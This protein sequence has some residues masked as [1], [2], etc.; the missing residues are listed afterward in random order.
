MSE[1]RWKRT[2]RRIAEL[3]GGRRMPISG[4]QRGDT[5]DVLHD[6][7]SIEVK[8]RRRLPGWLEEAMKQAEAAAKNGQLPV[9]VL[10]QDSRRY[11][12]CLVVLRLKDFAKYYTKGKKNEY[13]KT[14]DKARRSKP[15]A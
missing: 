4:R 9:A 5:P 12:D 2:E 15:E 10:H 7:L 11:R 13:R 6:R 8:S 3:L 14:G 1:K